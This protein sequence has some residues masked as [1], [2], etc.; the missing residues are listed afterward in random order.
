MFSAGG[1]GGR[2]PPR[3]RILVYPGVASASGAPCTAGGNSLAVRSVGACLP[4]PFPGP[5]SGARVP[6]GEH[7]TEQRTK[8]TMK[9]EQA[10]TKQKQTKHNKTKQNKTKQQQQQQQQQQTNKQTN[11]PGG[12]RAAAFFKFVFSGRPPIWYFGDKY[13]WR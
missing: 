1:A 7:K 9:K 8:T 2:S 10:A 12:G 3:E 13:F 6:G 4:N 11:R 5:P